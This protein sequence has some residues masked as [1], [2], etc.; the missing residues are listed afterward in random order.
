MEGILVDLEKSHSG[1]TALKSVGATLYSQ[2]DGESLDSRIARDEEA[3][4]KL[5][6]CIQ[7][8]REIERQKR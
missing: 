6:V 2:P 3:I 4:R 1:L 7:N 5:K 8:L